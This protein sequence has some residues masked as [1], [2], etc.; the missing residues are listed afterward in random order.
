MS[1]VITSNEVNMETGKDEDGVAQLPYMYRN[2]LKE[3]ITIP[4]DSEVAVQSVKFSRDE[5]ATVDSGDIFYTMYNINL[6][7]LN[8][9]RTSKN[10]TGYPIKNRLSKVDG[11]ENVSIDVLAERITTAMRKG[12]P[13]P[14]VLGE[15]VDD[16][17]TPICKMLYSGGLTE[18][19]D[20][21]SLRQTNYE[22]AEDL[23]TMSD[24]TTFSKLYDDGDTT[25]S[26]SLGVFT[27]PASNLATPDIDNIGVLTDQPIS[28][29]NGNMR[30]D[31][32]GVA[33]DTTDYLVKCNCAFGLSRAFER[34]DADA[35]ED[36]MAPPYFNSGGGT[37]GGLRNI[38]NDQFYDFGIR[39]ENET[40]GGNQ[41]LKVVCSCSDD[42]TDGVMMK[43]IVYYGWTDPYPGITPEFA[44]KYDMT[45]NTK[46]INQFLF[47]MEGEQVNLYYH[48]GALSTKDNPL[49]DAGWKIFC[50]F[51]MGGGYYDK[52]YNNNIPN[53][54]KQTQWMMYPMCYISMDKID[55]T[56]GGGGATEVGSLEL[57]AYSGRNS[58]LMGYY[59]PDSDWWARS[60]ID[61]E[62]ANCEEVDIRGKFSDPFR[63]DTT[64][65]TQP[66]P[67]V[68]R[69]TTGYCW[70]YGLLP[71]D[72]FYVENTDANTDEL[73]G[74]KGVKI[75]QPDKF[76][77]S[78][79]GSSGWRYDSLE[80]PFLISDASLFVRLDNFTQKTLNSAVSRPSKILYHVPRFDSSSR[81][82][83]DGLYFEPHQRVYTKL[84]NAT[85]L[86][87]NEFDISICNVA[88]ILAKDLTG[89]TIVVLHF[90]ENQTGFR[91]SEFLKRE[92]DEGVFIQ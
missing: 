85:A 35:P 4:R 66:A 13:H 7:K 77:S 26:Y 64:F 19:F 68:S 32:G 83:G 74:F 23:E 38:G 89:Q 48:T 2:Y 60:L 81:S 51:K 44:T 17:V 87:V 9:G 43:E 24:M 33:V 16:D 61:G 3:T 15:T 29:Y 10:T 91:Q 8:D 50:G 88:D 39:L 58:S 63:A 73:F 36:H 71:D 27:A 40:V 69:Q 37:V 78:Y 55:R 82:N 75:L 80:V 18:V 52:D 49:D 42:V 72:E 86:T 34:G 11:G 5:T 84:F 1:L 41:M 20:G 45:T 53:P 54:I 6:Q 21:F 70:A 12:F 59:K 62:E 22:S 90:R 56:G 79:D 67:S 92:K 30:W 65:Y 47:R 31:I 28:L 25:L 46:K 14:D 76:G 57:S